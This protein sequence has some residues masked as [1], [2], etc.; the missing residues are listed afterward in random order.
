[1]GDLE[2]PDCGHAAPS[3]EVVAEMFDRDDK[4]MRTVITHVCSDC[5]GKILDSIVRALDHA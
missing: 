4:V 5:A 2:A 3:V 1:M